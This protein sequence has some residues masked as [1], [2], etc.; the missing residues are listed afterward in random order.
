MVRVGLLIAFLSVAFVRGAP[1]T[2]PGVFA[3]DNLVAWCIVPFDAAKRT[4]EQRAEMMARLGIK[5]YAYDWRAEHLPTLERELTAIRKHGIELTAVWFP[6][7][8]NDEAKFILAALDKHKIRTQLW[9]TCGASSVDEGV[10]IIR[11]I[12]EAA[13]KIGCSVGLYNHGGWFGEPEN[14]LAI[15]ERLKLANVG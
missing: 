14:Q 12:A 15:I 6:A 4:P 10:K 13:A 1:A 11:P 5:R 9:V 7:G 8:L 2:Q 3:R